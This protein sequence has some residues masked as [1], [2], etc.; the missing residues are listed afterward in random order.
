MSNA[1][2]VPQSIFNRYD[3]AMQA[4]LI[5]QGFTVVSDEKPKAG[6]PATDAPIV[7]LMNDDD[8]P[9]DIAASG[10]FINI[11]VTKGDKR[12]KLT[13]ANLD[14]DFVRFT[15]KD[16][17]AENVVRNAIVDAVAVHGFEAAAEKIT[18]SVE[19][20]K[21]GETTAIDLMA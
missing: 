18:F 10:L 5:S 9:E 1:K 7:D 19:L 8:E 15:D 11:F 14:S 17:T 20:T 2:I 16:H 6:F 3:A 4:N 12:H 21:K 13:F